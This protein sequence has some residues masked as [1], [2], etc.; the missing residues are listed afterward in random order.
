LASTDVRHAVYS[1]LLAGLVLSGRHREALRQRG[2]TDAEIDRRS[3]RSLPGLGRPRMVSALREQFGDAIF[4][5]PGIVARQKY[6]RSYPTVA[7]AAGLLVPVRDVAERI[8][9][10][11]V[12]R[13]TDGP[14]KYVW[15]TSSRDGGPGPGA[16]VHT[17]LGVEGPAEVV[18]ITE[19]PL[20]ADIAAA[21]TGLP[22]IGLPGATIWQPALAVLREMGTMTVRLALDNDAESKPGVGRAL[23]GLA[24]KAAAEGFAVEL[25]RWQPEYK[26]IDDAL[27]ASAPLKVLAGDEAVA[28]VKAIANAAG[29]DDTPAVLDRLR[30]AITEG[31]EAL[32]RDRN[33]L[34]DLARLAVEDPGE[35]AVCRAAA[36]TAGIALRD[37]ERALTAFRHE[38]T[39][40][41]P[42]PDAV[43][44]YRISGG[45]I[46]RDQPT[47]DGPVEVPLAT[48]SARIIEETTFD[49]GAERRT[50][51][52]IEGQLADGTPLPRSEIPARDFPWMRWPVEVWGAR[53]V[54][55]AGAT[56]ADHLRT[57]IQLLSGDVVKRTVYTHVGWREYGG[58]WSYLHAG[59]AIGS[60]GTVA[61]IEV[62]LPEPLAGYALPDPPAGTDLT[63]AIRASLA[64]LDGLAP[65]R[66]VVPLLAAV[67]R[68]VLGPADY[69]LHLA[70]PTGAGKT[71]LAALLQ[72]H[73]GAGLDA[74]NLPASWSST[75][76]SLEGV[77]HAAKDALLTVDD[78]APTGAV[79]DNQRC[80][81]EADRLLRAQGNRSGRGRLRPDGTLRPAR[82]PR[83]TILST[84]EDVPLGQSL[85]S[86]LLVLELAPGD[87]SWR[88]LTACQADARDGRYAAALAGFL[89]WLAGRY[90]AVRE[91]LHV[92]HARLRDLARAEA[93]HARTPG[94]VADLML[95]LRFFLQ[96]AVEICAITADEQRALDARAWRALGEAAEAQGAHQG[97]AEPT[98][99]FL[100]LLAAALAS[101]R[102]HLAGP[103][104]GA[105]ADATGWGWRREDTRDGPLWKPQ[106]KRIGWREGDAVYLEPEASYAEAQRL[107]ADQGQALAVTPRT[108]WRRMRERG[109]LASWEGARQRLTIRRRLDGHE[110]REVIHLQADAL[111]PCAEPAQSSPMAAPTQPAVN[112]LGDGGG[113]VFGPDGTD[114]PHD[115]PQDS[116][117]NL[118]SDSPG[119]DGD[120]HQQSIAPNQEF[121]SS[122]PRW[123]GSL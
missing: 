12:R 46:V 43:G 45:R 18:R 5:V 50:V 114:R 26:G 11:L 41:R 34:R 9:A 68:A 33:L 112:A 38:I 58:Q 79:A 62:T 37:L 85:R 2:L 24:D 47:K 63:A 80:H 97:D 52:A 61:G 93:C 73:W 109:L 6:N 95:G 88:R 39:A 8:V 116:K 99:H 110:R 104:G 7:G 29:L 36:K 71:E 22:T 76:N 1:A 14:S 49:D 69:A 42:L 17:S 113:D 25:E 28:S 75:G 119:V 84:G 59:G 118:E 20:K 19:G 51:L 83:G 21:L 74:R 100:R 55:L 108:L 103:E 70:G 77:A 16:P 13:D 44:Q 121:W 106:G 27:A 117:V 65:D 105:P 96:F 31:I 101:G 115:H 35:Y 67:C 120:G 53:A 10:L 123:K 60:S 56:T 98:R 32:F 87:L 122:Q 81:R 91:G 57:A 48:W 78:F 90:A 4:G 54:V 92:E 40:S 66:V 64:L 86:R 23:A 94:I 72:Q 3:Y 30:T 82:A 15:L 89:Q 107:A 111:S 102:C